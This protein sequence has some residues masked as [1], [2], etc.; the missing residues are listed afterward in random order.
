MYYSV[1]TFGSQ[2]SAIGYATSDTMEAGSWADG[3]ST[4]IQSTTGE[5][6]NAIDGALI[7]SGSSYSMNFGSFWGDIYQVAMNGAATASSGTNYVQLAYNSSG[8][9][10][11]E[12]SYMY[13]RSDY[14]YLF[15]SSGVC[16]GYDATKPAPGAE[17]RIH[18]CR[19]QSVSGPF[20]DKGGNSCLSGGGTVVLESH[21]YVYGPG[22][23]GVFSD[24]DHG[25]VLYYHYGEFALTPPKAVPVACGNCG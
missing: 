2:E 6:F 23:Q 17:Y 19:S 22:G 7:Q 1:S 16:C 10:A 12:G 3:G 21:D 18:V 13:Y 14:Y 20:V 4:G 11:V 5:A 15:F 24:P 9:H 8:S 25:T